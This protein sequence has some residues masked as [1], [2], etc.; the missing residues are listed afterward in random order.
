MN[1]EKTYTGLEIIPD[2]MINLRGNLQNG[3]RRSTCPFCRDTR[4]HPNDPSFAF[5]E[6]TGIGICFHCGAVGILKSKYD[7]WKEENE[8]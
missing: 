1:F 8:K 4:H 3:R 7:K 5:N 2:E 6:V